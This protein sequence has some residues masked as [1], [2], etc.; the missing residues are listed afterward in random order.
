MDKIAKALVG[1][2]A[3][4]YAVFEFA[5]TLSSPAGEGITSNEW[6]RIAVSALLGGLAVWAVP[7]APDAPLEKK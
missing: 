6:I 2:L 7:N 5:T 3:A 4:G 1:A